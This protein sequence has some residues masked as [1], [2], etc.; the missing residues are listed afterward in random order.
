MP[1]PLN[2]SGTYGDDIT[3]RP[4]QS[5]FAFNGNF[6]IKYLAVDPSFARP[7]EFY[8][9]SRIV[10][11]VYIGNHFGYEIQ[12]NFAMILKGSADA[13]NF[14]FWRWTF[15]C[16]VD[17]VYPDGYVKSGRIELGTELVNP[18]VYNYKEVS[19]PI[20]FIAQ[21]FLGSDPLVTIT[22]DE[23]YGYHPPYLTL[24][25]FEK[26][27]V[28]ANS[29]VTVTVT[30]LD[31]GTVN[32]NFHVLLSEAFTDYDYTIN[33][34]LYS[35]G[36]TAGVQDLQLSN[37]TLNALAIPDY[38]YLHEIDSNN[39]FY[40]T[41]LVDAKV[42]GT[43][44]AFGGSV[45]NFIEA[46]TSVVL[47]RNIKN[48]G[49]I[50][51]WQSSYPDD[52]DVTITKFDT[53]GR[54]ITVSGGNF[55]EEE[56]F[57]KYSF[58][59]NIQIGGVPNNQSLAFDNLPS[60]YIEN[61]I[62]SASLIANDDYQYA[63]RL[64]FRAWWKPGATIYHSKNTILAGAG[65]T[66]TYNSPNRYN[67]SGYRYLDITGAS[68]SASPEPAKLIITSDG[69]TTI[70]EKDLVWNTGSQTKRIDLCFAGIAHTNFLDLQGQDN[71]YPRYNAAYPPGAASARIIN[72]DMYGIGQIGSI[73]NNGNILISQIKLTRED[74]TG[75]ASFVAPFSRFQSAGASIN[76]GF[77]KVQ[78]DSDTRQYFGRR[79]WE[80][81]LS[82]KNEEEYDLLHEL[83]LG[84][85]VV[86]TIKLSVDDLCTN[87]NNRVGYDGGKIHI[88]WTASGSFNPSSSPGFLQY[89]YDK[90]NAY[91]SWLNGFGQQCIAGASHF[92][93]LRD[94]SQE[95]GDRD[96][97][98]QMIFD[99][100]NCNYPPD[101]F[102][103][104]KLEAPGETQLLLY[105]FACLR[106]VAHGLVQE[107]QLGE[108][109][110]LEDTSGNLWGQG[111]TDILGSYQTALPGGLPENA[112]RIGYSTGTIPITKLFTAKRFRGAFYVIPVPV[113]VNI[114]S[115]DISGFYQGCIGTINMTDVDLIFSS[116]PDFSTFETLSTNITGMSNVAIAWLHPTNSNQMIL[117][118]QRESD[119]AILRYVL[120][121]FV[122]GVA[123]MAT[124]IGNG[125]TPA[126]A[127]N[128]NGT[129][130]IFWRTSSSNIQRII[131]DS[132]GNVTT[133]AS[134]VVVGNV[135][136]KGLGT[137]WL[138][139]V[140]YLVYDHTIN[141][142][143]VVKS[144]DYGETFS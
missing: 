105:S 32:E 128:G 40:Q 79:F 22:Q 17:L 77:V 68:A 133:A 3:L 130:I 55:E 98:T 126:I 134:N 29:N 65:N 9:Y 23:S 44:D 26:M 2:I 15:V 132:A 109:V 52:L 97:Y 8:E 116:T 127:I 64:P 51:S 84:G 93:I 103:A 42:Q 110:N 138:D 88:G 122:N 108:I 142:L 94:L 61:T 119:S 1:S 140:P 90:D 70:L 36:T 96:I 87:I 136:D 117:A 73:L 6:T 139:D 18:L 92:S 80:Q 81:D 4:I 12:L 43:D 35:K 91:A 48:K 49:I 28:N 125:S 54:T 47:E 124:V 112:A 111:T 63:T 7:P 57:Q 60:G 41:N 58:N 141:G 53:T 45:L 131:I 102:D 106:S 10:E 114:L 118:T 78:T 56:L 69:S 143:T 20:T 27:P 107:Q 99:R 46:N 113:G 14:G 19:F 123:G 89:V 50:H 71:P 121:D 39:Y 25:L 135:E 11:R 100:I 120:D 76:N 21:A 33:T 59:S 16:D 95:Y 66:R 86:N 30:G 5:R 67:L 74:N 82:G 129:Q 72:E 13:P 144:N 75:K 34:R 62:S 85:S 83:T 104:F 24:D 31:T 137:Y 115:A 37:L 101:Y 38:T